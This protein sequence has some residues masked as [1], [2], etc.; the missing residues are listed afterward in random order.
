MHNI[1]VDEEFGYRYWLWISPIDNIAEINT[2]FNWVVNDPKFF[3]EHPEKHFYGTWIE[4]ESTKYHQ[5]LENHHH[6]PLV[7]HIH[8]SD[9]SCLAFNYHTKEVSDEALE[10]MNEAEERHTELQPYCGCKIC[11][12]EEIQDYMNNHGQKEDSE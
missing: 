1:L 5:L 9:D 8:E 7:A 12:D 2:H 4:L 11:E 10:E 6:F 3:C